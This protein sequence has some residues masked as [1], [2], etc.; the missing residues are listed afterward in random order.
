MLR[1]SQWTG[2]ARI[3]TGPTTATERQSVLPDWRE[4]PR[5]GRLCWKGTCHTPGPLWLTLLTGQKKKKKKYVC[6]CLYAQTVKSVRKKTIILP[7]TAQNGV[8]GLFD[9]IL[10]H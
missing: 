4:L 5:P 2:L 6:K 10:A 7:L 9:L 3:C 8:L 1:E